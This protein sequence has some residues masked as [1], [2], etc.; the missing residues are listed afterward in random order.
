[1][2]T[3]YKLS[4]WDLSDLFDS[5]DGDKIKAA[6]GALREDVEA[7]ENFREELTPG[8][9]VERFQAIAACIERITH[10][11][12]RIQAFAGLKFSEDTQKQD[13]QAFMAEIQHVMAGL[14]NKT[15]FFELWWKNLDE[16]NAARLMK[17]SGDWAY[18]L[19]EM[20]HFKPHTLTE[21]EE[22]IINIKDVTGIG[23]LTTLYDSITN[24]Y[25]FKI[26][27]DGAEKSMTRG[28]LMVFARHHD[29]DLRERAYR[30][31]YRV[32]GYDG[33][34]LGQMYQTLI[35]D[36]SAEHVELRKH[37]SPMSVRNLSND[38]PDDVVDVLLSVCERNASIFQDFFKLKAK[39]L[40]VPRLRRCDIYAPVG[41]SDKL[42]DFNRAAELVLSA[43]RG[44]DRRFADAARSIFQHNHVDSEVR[45]GK[46]DGAFCASVVPELV[47][48][49]LLSF[50]GKAGDVATL[51]HELGHAVHAVLASGHSVFTFESALPLAENASTFGEMLLL[52]HLLEEETDEDV[53]RDL[54]FRQMDDAYATIMRQAFFAIFERQAH[55]LTRQGR[56]IDDLADAYYENLR[57]QF[58]DSVE[59]SDE[60]RWEWVS[61]PHFYHSPFYVYAYSFGQLLV[62][63]LYREYKKDKEAFVPR[64]IRILEAGGSASP[65][66]IL[67]EAGIDIHK[68]E[69]WQGGFEVLKDLLKQLEKYAG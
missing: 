28:E 29:P 35:R 6:I 3:E 61:I 48:W 50:Q 45:T 53:R 4:S 1:M 5:I 66:A 14:A 9:T 26:E 12:N 20:R 46:R 60:F 57:E 58:K 41:E 63:S 69:F 15:L 33:P 59:L 18:W 13:V 56:T 36:W 42:Y 24:R 22:K 55:D 17:D 10:N 47:P 68:A 25:Q 32:Y 30:E 37:P 16:E 34:I 64:Y 52:D 67:S 49:V 21:P 11:A 31:L 8:I 27:V 62:F 51:A 2:T 54:L 65:A 44:F 40:G 38:L 7:F 19:E 23:A 39:I 43:F